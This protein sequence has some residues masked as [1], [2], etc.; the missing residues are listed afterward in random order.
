MTINSGTT[1]EIIR[2]PEMHPLTWRLR[3]RNN[4]V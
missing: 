2:T 3:D 1:K 4:F